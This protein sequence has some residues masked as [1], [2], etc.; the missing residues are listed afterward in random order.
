MLGKT[1]IRMTPV[2]VYYGNGFVNKEGAS[3]YANPVESFT[4]WA[5]RRGDHKSPLP[6]SY[7]RLLSTGGGRI[8]RVDPRGGGNNYYYRVLAAYPSGVNGNFTDT[9]YNKCIDKINGKVRGDLDLSVDAFQAKQTAKQFKAGDL[10]LDFFND[11]SSWDRRHKTSNNVAKALAKAIPI[12]KLAGALRLTW[13]YGWKPL[14][15][16]FYGVLDEGLRT[17]INHYQTYNAVS[18][19]QYSYRCTGFVDSGS[20]NY[21]PFQVNR[22][23]SCRVCITLDTT[24]MPELANWTS[25]NPASIAWELLP[26]SFVFDWFVD[27]GGSLRSLETALLYNRAFK[28]GFVSRIVVNKGESSGST[29]DFGYYKLY[30]TGRWAFT[31]VNFDRTVLTSFPIRRLPSVDVGLSSP[32]LFNAI[33]LLTQFLGKK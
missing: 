21:A 32:R 7:S 31:S 17:Y 5:L 3:V 10:V 33:G 25:L 27:V 16:D 29:V 26:F 14:I 9:L 2:P 1:N 4:G 19:S 28:N 6:H 15:Q 8:E 11:V 20:G 30:T 24:K 12:A 18:R 22:K 23:E 13:V